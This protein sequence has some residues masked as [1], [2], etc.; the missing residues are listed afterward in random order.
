MTAQLLPYGVESVARFW[1]ICAK[2]HCLSRL[3]AY[4]A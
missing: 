1:G 2:V 3:K 4:N